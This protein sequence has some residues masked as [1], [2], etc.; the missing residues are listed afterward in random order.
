MLSGTAVDRLSYGFYAGM[1][2]MTKR[3]VGAERV[4][5]AHTS[6]LLFITEGSRDRI[7]EAG[8]DAEAVEGCCL[9]A[10]ST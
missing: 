7:L 2:H 5:V 3:Q 4:C 6:T 8:A 1:K 9:L 10:C